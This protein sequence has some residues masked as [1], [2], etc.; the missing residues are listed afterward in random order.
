MGVDI[1]IDLQHPADVIFFYPLIRQLE[2]SHSLY[3]TSR[4]RDETIKLIDSFGINA[5]PVLRDYSDPV[6]KSLAVLFRTVQLY[7]RIPSFRVAL[8]LELP[9]AVAVSYL[10][11]KNSILF[12]DNDFK[13]LSKKTISQELEI[14][15]KKLATRI[16]I[17]K[18]TYSTFVQEYDAGKLVCYN[19]YKEHLAISGY[20]PDADFPEKIPFGDN[21]V[22][23]R[24]EAFSAMYVRPHKES[25]V[26]NLVRALTKENIPVLFIPRDEDNTYEIMKYAYSK[27]LIHIPKRPLNGL[28]LAYFAKA[29]LTGSGTMAREAAVLGTPAVSFF[30]SNQLLSVDMDLIRR[31]RMIHSRDVHEIVDYVISMWGKKK[32]PEFK[33]AEKVKNEVISIISELTF[34]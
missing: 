28:D 22:V 34:S 19:G 10:R 32:E 33:R 17:P 20:T 15:V 9:V 16:V 13:L 24:S 8:C 4:R 6:R 30:P 14:K 27:E 2:D 7:T 3:I 18:V 21:Y 1:W 29:V 26:P 12:L 23:I 5:F 31:G 25:L 11:K